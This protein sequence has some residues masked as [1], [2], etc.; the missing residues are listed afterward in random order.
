MKQIRVLKRDEH[1]LSQ[2]VVECAA[3]LKRSDIWAH[4]QV[5]EDSEWRTID[6]ISDLP[7]ALMILRGEGFRVEAE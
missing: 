3:A 5:L 6:I 2:D 1:A 4:P 7:H